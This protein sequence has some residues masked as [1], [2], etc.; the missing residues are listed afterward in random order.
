MKS[1]LDP[2]FRYTPAAK[3]DLR[4]TFA[5]IRREQR[6]AAVEASAA[7]EQAKA[8]AEEAARVV[9]PLKRKAT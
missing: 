5:R 1:I 8:A 9:R 3:T 2:A 4:K 6:Q 7:E